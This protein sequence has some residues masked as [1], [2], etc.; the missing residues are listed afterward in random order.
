MGRF[1]Y[2]AIDDAQTIK[3]SNNLPSS[4]KH[5]IQGRVKSSEALSEET[6]SQQDEQRN[7]ELAENLTTL[8]K[9]VSK[10]NIGSIPNHEGNRKFRRLN[11]QQKRP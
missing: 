5:L 3:D 8:L 2:W 1:V 11:C 9:Q 4:D 6:R 10:V 7:V